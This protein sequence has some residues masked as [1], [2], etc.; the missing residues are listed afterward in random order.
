[1]SKERGRLHV[2]SAAEVN[3]RL[4]G[5]FSG[6]PGACGTYSQPLKCAAHKIGKGVVVLGSYC[7]ANHGRRSEVSE[8]KREE[9]TSTE[10]GRARKCDASDILRCIS[11][12]S[13]TTFPPMHAV[14]FSVSCETRIPNT[15]VICIVHKC[16][17]NSPD[18]TNPLYW[19]QHGREWATLI[20][21]GR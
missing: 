12:Q 8:K 14:E 13:G 11:T 18:L 3:W 1:M 17:V 2:D 4:T 19:K 16:V 7:V 21:N 6:S 20:S 5:V 15:V 10:Y 9:K